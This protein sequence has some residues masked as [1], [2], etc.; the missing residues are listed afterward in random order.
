MSLD[1]IDKFVQSHRNIAAKLNAMSPAEREALNNSN[2]MSG[3]N[4]GLDDMVAMI[5]KQPMM[6]DA[7][8]SAGL[9]T[10]EWVLMTM[11]IM[12]TGMAAAVLKTRPNDN[13]DS[14]MRSMKVNPDNV[15]FYNEHE[16][17]IT[18]KMKAVDTY[19]KSPGGNG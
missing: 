18:A 11:S 14:L 9:S 12:Q 6:V 4:M 7:I 5:D 16:A 15:R 1:G 19:Y 8:K 2:D 13:Q 17:E 10:R 3:A